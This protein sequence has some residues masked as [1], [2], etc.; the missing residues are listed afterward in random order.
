MQDHTRQVVAYLTLRL[1]NVPDSPFLYDYQQEQYVDYRAEILPNEKL[2]ALDMQAKLY[3]LGDF[4]D[5]QYGLF[6]HGNQKHLTLE[7]L[8]ETK[9]QGYDFDADTYYQATV[10][11]SSVS[12]FDYKT[13]TT[14]HYHLHPVEQATPAPA[15]P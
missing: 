8:S 1:A 9:V 7:P 15:S 12:V 10:N 3:I 4:N 2:V 6:H 13:E 5:G 14:T 11:G